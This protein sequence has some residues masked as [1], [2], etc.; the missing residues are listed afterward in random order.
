MKSLGLYFRTLRHS[1]ADQLVWRARYLLERRGSAVRT[2]RRWQWQST[3]A[4]RLH[5]DFPEL[6][7][8]HRATPN[9]AAALLFAGEFRHLHKSRNLGIH[10]PDWPL[11]SIAKDRLWVVTLHYHEWAYR[12]A[13]A[14]RDD[15]GTE[16]AALFQALVSDWI[17]R[18][19]LE[20]PGALS[21]AWNSYAIACRLGRWVLAYRL[22][23]P[24]YW[25]AWPAFERDFLAS[26]WQQAAYLYDHLEWDVRGNHLLRDALGLAVAGRYFAE[27]AAL[28]WLTRA[29]QLALE[30]SS[31]QVLADG[32]HFERSPMYHLQVMEDLAMLVHLLPDADTRQT[33]K[34]RWMRM[35]EFAAWMRHPDGGI[36]LFNDAALNG[37][38]SPTEV[39]AHAPS[40]GLSIDVAPRRGGRHFADTGMAVWHGHPWSVFFDMG[41]V[42][43]DYQ[44]GHAH[45]DTL[46]VE[47]SYRGTRLFVDPGTYAY[48]RDAH[49]RYDRST[50]SHN[51]VCIDECDSTEV[52]HI[53]RVG[54]RALPE[55]VSV[56]FSPDGMDAS[57]CHDG[58]DH[59]PD[60]PRHHRRVVVKESGEL[61]LH[62]RIESNGS[63]TA[64]AGLL[65]APEWTATPEAGGWLLVNGDHRVRV[66]V[67]GPTGL[68]LSQCHR[69]YHPEFGREQD[70]TRL[71]WR[72]TGTAPME[73]AVHVKGL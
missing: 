10:Q 38:G 18:C 59:L 23:G 26:A 56:G 41:K 9:D 6:P 68:V 33:L 20:A 45:A 73:A 22:L 1:R 46:S 64:E 11:G 63:H 13:E 19:G 24:R 14:A 30:Q 57:A 43:P 34:R 58:F 49:R 42:G 39:L 12:L 66:G 70:T 28:H 8:P 48:D 62:D 29:A 15:G 72:I 71:V 67:T 5:D 51:T 53:F 7:I 25:R 21:L 54:R 27:E 36:P 50:S 44:P 32:G 35:A 60:R 55:H 69:P 2:P 4:P 52:W 17:E 40:L 37:A 31:E 65:L 3:R 47:A 16:A 61:F